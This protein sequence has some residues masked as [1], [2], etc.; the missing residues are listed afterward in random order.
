MKR[1]RPSHYTS[2]HPLRVG[3]RKLYGAAAAAYA[4]AHGHRA[5]KHSRT[6]H[7]R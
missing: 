2:R 3:R 6:A 1:H 4:K 7:S 5:R